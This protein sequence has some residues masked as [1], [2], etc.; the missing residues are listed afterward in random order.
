MHSKRPVLWRDIAIS[1]FNFTNLTTREDWD[2]ASKDNQEAPP[3]SDFYSHDPHESFEACKLACE[4]LP[5]C[6]QWTYH[7][8]KCKINNFLRFGEHRE[9]ELGKIGKDLS[10]EESKMDWSP[11]DLKFRAGWVQDKVRRRVDERPC[12]K[13]EWVRPSLPD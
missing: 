13:V 10:E 3:R 4:A 2:N 11:D 1:Y 5:M 8:R 6:L 9:P 12:E 7:L